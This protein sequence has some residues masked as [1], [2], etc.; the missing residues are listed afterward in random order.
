MY[1]QVYFG[2]KDADDRSSEMLNRKRN[3]HIRLGVLHEV[4]RA[5]VRLPLQGPLKA[6]R[7]GK[8]QPRILRHGINAGDFRLL[9]R[10][11]RVPPLQLL[12]APDT[13]AFS[14]QTYIRVKPCSGWLHGSLS[15]P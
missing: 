7:G 1:F 14:A 11:Y 5:V 12:Q 8:I 15:L 2:L 4:D 6:A 13:E 3:R 10:C 9:L